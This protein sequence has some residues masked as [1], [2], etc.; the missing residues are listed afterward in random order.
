MWPSRT[1][2]ESPRTL[3][4]LTLLVRRSVAPTD[5]SDGVDASDETD[6]HHRPGSGEAHHHPPLQ[7]SASLNV[8]GDVQGAA[9]PEVIHRRALFTLLIV[10]CQGLSDIQITRYVKDLCFDKSQ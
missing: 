10:A 5:L 2:P 7:R 4:F 1:P 9:V 3:V 8:G 6:V